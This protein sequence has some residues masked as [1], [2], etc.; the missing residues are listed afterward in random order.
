[1]RDIQLPFQMVLIGSGDYLSSTR[2]IRYQMWLRDD[3]Y[4]RRILEKTGDR[5]ESIT[6]DAQALHPKLGC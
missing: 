1:M 3:I 5:S 6:P 2:W 4:E